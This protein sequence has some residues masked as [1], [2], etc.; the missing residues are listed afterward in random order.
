MSFLNK[1]TIGYKKVILES[2]KVAKEASS[3]EI[4]PEHLFYAL[5]TQKG[6]LANQILKKIKITQ[7]QLKKDLFGIKNITS[8][9][10]TLP[11]LSVVSKNLIKKSAIIASNFNHHFV[12]TEHLL[13]VILATDNQQI[14][15]FLHK[16]KIDIT[17]LE[18]QA[19]VSI[20]TISK[21]SEN[22]KTIFKL[23]NSNQQNDDFDFFPQEN[24]TNVS[25]ITE[26]TEKKETEKFD[27]VIGREKEIE[28]IIQVLCRRKKNNPLLLG[29]PGVGKTAIIEGLAKKITE[30]DVP[31]SLL[32]KKIIKLDLG[33]A[34][35]GTMFRGEF[36]ARLKTTIEEI[37]NDPNAILFIDEIHNIV[38]AG[39]SNGSL[40]AANILKPAL[41][42]AE[43]SVIGTTTLADYKKHIEKD[44]ALLRRFE[45][46]KTEEPTKEEAKKILIN[47]K[48]YYEDFHKIEI[49]DSAI[50]SAI[51]LSSR[52]LTDKFLPDKA[53]DLID[54]AASGI[55][56]KKQKYN[57][58]FVQIEFEKKFKKIQ[59]E[60]RKYINAENY[61]EAIKLREDEIKLNREYE[62]FKHLREQS[63][64]VKIGEITEQDIAQV[65]S[66]MTNIPVEKLNINDKKNIAD[67]E[68]SLS[69]K[70]IGQSKA[71]SIVTK[72]LKRALLDMS[73]PDRPL[74]SF[75]F[76]G[77]TGVGKTQLTKEIA[78]KVFGE[79][80]S[81]IKLD[82]SE[83]SDKFNTSKLIGA[84]A[85]YV[86]YDE[87]G[88]LTEFVKHNPYSLVL[89]DEIEKAHPDIFNLLL[90]IL[91][92]GI[93]TDASGQAV[94]FKNTL[95]VLTSNIGLSDFYS[96]EYIGFGSDNKQEINFEE[97]SEKINKNL[98]ASV[99]PE[100][101]GRLDK[102][103]IFNPLNKADI[104]QIVKLQLDELNTRLINKHIKLKSNKLAI[105][106]LSELAYSPD[107]GARAVRKTIQDKVEDELVEMMLKNKKSGRIQLGKGEIIVEDM[108]YRF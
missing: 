97:L 9:T 60:K 5:I 104:E 42:R 63:E 3:S 91:E 39:A 8:I 55:K 41:S 16:Y 48:K 32:G 36:E 47:L 89:F 65:I 66:K 106:Y 85:G 75:L 24:N 31:S 93:L 50:D 46:V 12:G 71:I 35:S 7:S 88:K 40:D 25:F 98:K 67:L 6:S 52:Y 96:K 68:K 11:D 73:H 101:L 34:I 14:A 51:N 76:L 10:S 19:N 69:N 61:A 81:F 2:Q 102:I 20:K 37:Q 94:N 108:E 13:S 57:I 54:E 72:Y 100:L 45:V 26:I 78:K 15:N 28:R 74:G 99:R 33:S 58:N 79:K 23:I 30:M 56:I 87:G 1:F 44:K 49:T 22:P 80:G 18:E 105:K 86:G 82:M 84:P 17:K 83:Y 77:P 59:D 103:L 53:I 64:K 107:Q 29:E 62:I 38:G 70:I 21:F 92:D 27:P 90:Q 43:F 95:I 4:N